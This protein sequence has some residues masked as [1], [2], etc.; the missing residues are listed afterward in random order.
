MKRILLIEDEADHAELIQRSLA[1]TADEFKVTYVRNLG[2]AREM[3]SEFTPD[4]A[5]VDF[6]LPDGR[7]DEFVAWA[8]GR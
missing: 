2:T 5:L 8:N 6:R 7:G 1:R 3:L 4:L